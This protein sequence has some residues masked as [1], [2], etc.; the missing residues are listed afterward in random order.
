MEHYLYLAVDLF[1]IFIPF[2]FSFHP[3]LRFASHWKSFW[4]SCVLIAA[5]FIIWDMLF[6]HIGVWGFNER[7]LIGIRIGNLPLEEF[8]F[9][10]CIPYSSVF[11]YHCFSVL[12]PKDVLDKYE[13]KTS[14]LLSIL[15]LVIGVLKINLW[16]TSVTFLGCGTFLL[17]HVLLFRFKWMS[18]FYLG[19]LAILPFF[20][21]TNGI[22]T[23]GF[24]QEPVVWYNNSENLGIRMFTIPTEDVFYGFLLLA[25]NVGIYEKLKAYNSNVPISAPLTS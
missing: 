22:L 8:I 16:Y 18:R 20:F 5:I 1:S 6:T 2:V 12:L 10:I 11:T 15:L 14:L 7:Y 9:F 13:N 21:I 23:G 24:T 25:L 4:P 19:Y 17:L 3:K